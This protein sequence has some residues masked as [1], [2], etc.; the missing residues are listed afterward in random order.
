VTKDVG[1]SSYFA[2]DVTD[3]E[4]PKYLWEFY[5]QASSGDMT[6]KLGYSTTGPAIVR[7]SAKQG[8]TGSYVAHPDHSKNG[9]W[10]AI[11]ASGP[12]GPI[13]TANHQFKGQSDQQLRLFVVDLAT[14]VLVRTI[15]NMYDPSPISGAPSP[16]TL[17]TYAFGGSLATSV[18]DTDR[19]NSS[20]DGFYTDDAVYIGYTQATSSSGPWTSGGVLRLTLKGNTDSSKSLMSDP[21]DWF[22]S[23]VLSGTGPVTTSVTKLQDRNNKLMW[24]YFGT[25]R[26][27]YKMDDLPNQQT[28][29]GVKEPCYYTLD[30]GARMPNLNR[31][32]GNNANAID[33]TCYDSVSNT[34]TNPIVDQTGSATTAPASTLSATAPGWLI[35]LDAASG[36]SLTERVITDPIA[37]GSGAVFFT[38]FKPNSDL[39]KYGGDSLI[40][41]LNYATGGVPPAASMQGKA[42]MQVSTGAFAEISL[43]TA[44]SN[45]ANLGYDKRRLATPISGVPPTAQGLSLLTNPP[46]VKK[47][48]HVREK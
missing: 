39:C 43:S 28:L 13:D 1:Y 36:G 6:G 40:W 21:A 37:A 20:S 19:W 35:N 38:T 41:A 26:Y 12:T 3:P 11:F 16:V 23:P 9:K 5:G 17:P 47:F 45:P 25:G 46:P 8:T 30:R 42:L 34:L 18:I 14:G 32:G 29:Y 44:F 2:L 10:Y 48:L 27:Y 22:V 7:V 15:E 24:L 31:T 4:S 33:P